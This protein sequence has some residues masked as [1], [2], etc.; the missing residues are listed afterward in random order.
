[1][2]WQWLLTASEWALLLPLWRR[3]VKD[4][5]WRVAA[6]VGTGLFWLIVIVAIASGGGDDSK[7]AVASKSPT[8]RATVTATPQDTVT[9]TPT[10]DSRQAAEVT[11][12]VDGDTIRV[13]IDGQSF[14]LRYIGI[15]TPETKDPNDPVECFGAEA[16]AANTAL[17]EGQTVLLEKDV[18]E[19]D[20]YG[21]LLRYVW[22]GETLV[23]EELV[24][25]GFAVSSTFPPDVKYQERF[26]VA[27]RQARDSDLGLWPA[28]GGA[29]TPLVAPE[30]TQPPAAQPEPTEPPASTGNCDPSYPTVCIAPP[31]P[32]LDCGEIPYRRFTVL[33]PDPHGFDGN[34]NDG[35]GCESG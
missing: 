26:T 20:R 9:P 32:D 8:P 11:S 23:N 7:K 14:T 24:A 5:R 13:T 34:D 33:P 6:A 18:S 3:V 30:P 22:L 16:T 2:R 19:T 35:I 12:V 27:E 25:Q 10:P 21:R 31:P 29:D 4:Q 1:M 15:D 17:V 28:C